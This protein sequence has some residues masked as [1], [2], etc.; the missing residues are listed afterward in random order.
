MLFHNPSENTAAGE[1]FKLSAVLLLILSA[2]VIV[3]K[4]ASSFS[5]SGGYFA[6]YYRDKTDQR[7]VDYLNS[8]NMV[9]L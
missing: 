5:T 4:V 8:F 3:Q 2:F 6:V 7:T 9:V 1:A